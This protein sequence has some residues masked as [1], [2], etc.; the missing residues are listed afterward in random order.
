MV[1]AGHI[2]KEV[3]PFDYTSINRRQEI[4]TGIAVVL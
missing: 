4:F 1:V 3:F 2:L